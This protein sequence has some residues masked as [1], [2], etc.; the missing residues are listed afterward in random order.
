MRLPFCIP[1]PTAFFWRPAASFPT[2]SSATDSCTKSRFTPR[3]ICPQ[4]KYRP[5]SAIFTAMS[6][7]ASSMTIMGSLPPSSRVTRLISRPATSM[8]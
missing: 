6:T 7:L 4:L 2:K 3:H 8:T 1:S 5:M